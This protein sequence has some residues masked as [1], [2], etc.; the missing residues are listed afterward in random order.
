[1]CICEGCGVWRE[2]NGTFV[3]SVTN[4]TPNCSIF[5]NLLGFFL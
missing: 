3:M 1:M 4:R 2:W 5:A